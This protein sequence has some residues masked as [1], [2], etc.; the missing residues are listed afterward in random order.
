MYDLDPVHTSAL[1]RYV[2]AIDTVFCWRCGR[3]GNLGTSMESAK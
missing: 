2:A 1:Y 3:S